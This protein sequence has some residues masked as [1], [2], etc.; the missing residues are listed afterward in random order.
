MRTWRP[1][2]TIVERIEAAERLDGIAETVSG[3]ARKLIP[4]GPVEDVLT[5]VPAGHP[6]HPA[7]VTVPI[8]AWM[9]VGLLDAFGEDTAARRLTA[10]GC[11]AAVP[12]AAAGASDWLST[13]GAERRVGLVHALGN[14]AALTA[15]GLSWLA[16]RRGQRA[17]GIALS[18]LGAG[19]LAG[20]GWLGGHLAY[21]RGVGVDTTAFQHLPQDWTDAGPESDIPAEGALARMDADGIPLL[22]T[23]RG[24]AV[25]ALADRCTHRGGPLH[26]GV[27]SGGRV[28]CPWHG[29]VFSLEDG[30]V[31][32]GPATRPEPTF[33]TRVQDGRLAVRRHDVATLRTKPIGR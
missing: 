18:V 22:V 19:L 27:V 6:L 29:S 32:S 25:I 33:E 2:E 26:E 1:L 4:P 10:L 17:R 5:G 8:G 16:R 12:A 31:R 30:T 11:V 21:G 15:Y 28:T 23:R 9:S 3:L 13:S 24:D 20:A 14:D 7:I